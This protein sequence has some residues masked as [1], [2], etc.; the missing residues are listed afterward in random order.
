[1]T[2]MKRP[3][4]VLVILLAIAAVRACLYAFVLIPPWQTPDE[5]GHFAYTRE[6]ADFGLRPPLPAERARLFSLIAAS[7]REEEFWRYLRPAS[8]AGARQR[9]YFA[10]VM[11]GTLSGPRPALGAVAPAESEYLRSQREDEPATYYVIPAL[12]SHLSSRIEDQLYL[13]RGWSIVLYLATLAGVYLGLRLLAPDDDFVVWVGSALAALSPMPAFVGAA[14]NNDVAAMAAA[15]GTLAVLLWGIRR[16]WTARRLLLLL[17]LLVAASLTKKTALF[18]WPT[19][20]VALGLSYRPRGLTARRLVCLALAGGAA[21]ILGVVAALWPGAAA[22]QWRDPATYRLATRAA[23]AHAGRYA[24]ALAAPAETQPTQAQQELTYAAVVGLRGQD[25][26]LTAW[27]RNPDGR[28]FGYMAIYDGRTTQRVSFIASDQWQPLSLRYR[29]ASDARRLGVTLNNGGVGR[30]LFD[31]LSWRDAGGRELLRNGDMERAARA[32]ESWLA[33][34]G[35]LAPGL[36]PRLWAAG[37][38]RPAELARYGLYGA[39]TLAGAWAN[40][41]WL[42]LPVSPVWYLLLAGAYALAGIGLWRGGWGDVN[43]APARRAWVVLAVALA[44]VVAQTFLPMIGTAW[45]PQGRYLFPALLP[46]GAL[47]AR[48]WRAWA[49][50]VGRPLLAGAL[51]VAMFAF[52]QVCMWGY[53]APSYAR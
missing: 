18:V 37:S 53:L 27:V 46:A 2:E 11:S 45:Q 47:L 28:G 43:A 31:D 49:P 10:L 25:L 34:R 48:G 5:P 39:L 40:F 35:A 16:G 1:M 21:L 8:A 22:S 19:A 52:E 7:L 9:I 24:L 4:I 50:Q 30:L 23:S 12:L 26:E 3:G 51:L 29:A 20:A 14:C 15:T 13:A 17:A 32:G 33:R 44:L 38:Y 36:Q 42:T 41:G 6:I